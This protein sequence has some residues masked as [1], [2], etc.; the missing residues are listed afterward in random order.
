MLSSKECMNSLEPFYGHANKKSEVVDAM[1]VS[2]LHTWF[3]TCC[4]KMSAAELSESKQ[5]SIICQKLQGPI[6]ASYILASKSASQKPQTLLDLKQSLSALFADSSVKFTDQAI[7]MQFN[8]QTLVSDI[9]TFET[10]VMHSSL[11]TSVNQNEF[12]YSTLRAKLHAARPNLLLHAS[13]EHGLSLDPKSDF[14]QYVQQALTIAHR[15]QAASDRPQATPKRPSRPPGPNQSQ[16]KAPRSSSGPSRRPAPAVSPEHAR[17]FKSMAQWDDAR[18]LQ[19]FGR[20]R[21]CAW[22]IRDNKH[23]RDHTCDPEKRESRVYAI[24]NSLAFG[25]DPNLPRPAIKRGPPKVAF[26]SG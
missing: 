11:A 4:W 17:E 19:R 10:Y 9:K 7:T 15:V 25:K 12:L 13:S 22:E 23:A 1:Y 21:H 14:S 24:K 8:S 3:D 16:N 5:M 26:S 2:H 20:C 18:I 6:L